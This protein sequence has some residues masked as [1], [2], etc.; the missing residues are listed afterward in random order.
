MRGSGKR[1]DEYRV[2]IYG[3]KSGLVRARDHRATILLFNEDS[4]LVGSIKFFDPG[5]QLS[6]DYEK[7]GVIRLFLSS[8]MFLEV[9][10]IL[11]N[12]KPIYIHGTP[13]EYYLS[14]DKE[15]VGEEE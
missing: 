12:E 13:G 10:D 1:V 2:I 7:H 3:G 6:E 8:D 4:D 5:M 14:T 11:R 9:V 15:P